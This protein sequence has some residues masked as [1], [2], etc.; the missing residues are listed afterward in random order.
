MSKPGPYY[1]AL[2]AL[3]DEAASKAL[4]RFRTKERFS[5][6]SLRNEAEKAARGIVRKFAIRLCVD[7]DIDERLALE[8]EF[9]VEYVKAYNLIHDFHARQLPLL[10]GF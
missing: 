3:Q 1:E 2:K 9:Q 4:K 5:A 10:A 7:Y 6:D 8:R